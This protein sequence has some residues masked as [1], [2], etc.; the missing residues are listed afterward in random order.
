MCGYESF[1]KEL[2]KMEAKLES[3][4][5]DSKMTVKGHGKIQHMQK[6]EWAIEIRDVYY[7]AKIKI[8]ILSIG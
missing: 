3:C 6:D 4:G 2:T 7:V 8:N 5:G 1:F